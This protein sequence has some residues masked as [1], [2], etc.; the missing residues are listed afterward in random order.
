M[1]RSE[2]IRAALV[3][4]A[5]RLED[6]RALSEEAAALEADEEDRKEMLAVSNFMEQL[7]AAR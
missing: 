2:V 7:R 4:A 1:S 3:Q 6:R 5:A